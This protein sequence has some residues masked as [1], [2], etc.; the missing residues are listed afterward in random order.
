MKDKIFIS[1]ATE[2]KIEIARPLAKLLQAEGYQVWFDEFK[3]AV[4]DSIMKSIDSGL[5]SC[6]YAIVIFSKS[7]FAK[8]KKWTSRELLS[9]ATRELYNDTK[10]ILPIWHNITLNELL[11][12]SPPLA[13][14]F[15]LNS[16]VGL[17]TLLNE[18]KKVL[19]PKKIIAPQNDTNKSFVFLKGHNRYTL[20]DP[21]G[22]LC[23]VKKTNWLYALD[24][25]QKSI[26]S[27]GIAGT[28]VIRN[29]VSN[30]GSIEYTNEAGTSVAYTK[31]QEPLIPYKI[32]EHTIEFEA[33]DCYEE[34]REAVAS[35]LLSKF[36]NI[37]NHV[38]FPTERTPTNVYSF[39]YYNGLR[40][41]IDYFISPDKLYINQI[42]NDPPS[43]SRL[44]LEWDW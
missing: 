42:I 11:L 27:G 8:D 20:L 34:K 37:G 14:K 18:I 7:F 41:E 5:N 29:V 16:K 35:N 30:L 44:I 36:E 12:I 43:G 38:F 9:L 23:L 22:H 25:N 4:G 19:S 17:D 24:E 10:I 33:V 28:G 1:H 39:L 13:D 3:L 32:Y 40:K 6:D 31:L 2:D 15:A 21:E 26:R